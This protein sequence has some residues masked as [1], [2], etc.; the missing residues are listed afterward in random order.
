[1][2]Y[3][4]HYSGFQKYDKLSKIIERTTERIQ[5]AKRMYEENSDVR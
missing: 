3:I 1:M 4:I 5:L 2:S